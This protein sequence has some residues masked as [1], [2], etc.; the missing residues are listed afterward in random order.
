M[1]VHGT[2][3]CR[4]VYTRPLSAEGTIKPT[5]HFRHIYL[6]TGPM[7]ET[8]H[9]RERILSFNDITIE[10]FCMQLCSQDMGTNTRVCVSLGIE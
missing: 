3:S 5:V 1:Y 9:A 7:N 4:N 6:T 10:A 2:V 8:T